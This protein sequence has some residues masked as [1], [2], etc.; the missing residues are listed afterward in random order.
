M[1]EYQLEL[2]QI[3]DY[4][5]CRIYRQF[6]G[7]LMK[8]K[9]IRVGGTS[10]LYHFTVLSCFANFRTSYKRID[11]I[12][13]TIYPGEWLCRVSE[14][15]EWFRTRFQHQALAILREL[16]DRH[17][18]TY[19]LL[20]RGKL[21]KFKIKGWCKY[22]RVLEYNAP[23]QK[24]TGFFFLPISVAN[25]LVSAG[26]CSEM[27]AMPKKKEEPEVTAAVETTEST[28]EVTDIEPV[29]V[30]PAAEVPAEPIKPAV[31][32]PPKPK[33][34]R[35]KKTDA[36]DE[37]A[38][39]EPQP[40]A[41]K[42]TAAKKKEAAAADRQNKPK[43]DPILTLEVGGEVTTETHEMDAAWHEIL[44]SN[45]S[46][47][48]LTGM[49]GGVEETEAGKT[50]AVVDYKGF[51]VVIPLKEMLV[52]LEKNLKGTEYTEMIRRQNKLLSNMLGCEIDFI[53]KGVDQKTRTVVASRKEAM[54]KKRQVFYMNQDASGAYRIY[55]GRTVQARVIAVAEKA[56]RI[57]AFGVECSI[58]ARDLS[59]DWIGD[60]NDRFSVGDQILVRI[61]EVN[62]DSLEELSIRADVKSVSENTN[63]T[64]LKQC[65][66]QSK[67]A[68]KVTDVHKGVVYVRLNNGAN[69][70]AHTCLD[71]RTPGKKD[72]VSFAVTH[73]DEDRS[74][75]V[76]IITRI[77]KQHL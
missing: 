18:N 31:E 60:A 32:E 17:L 4:P 75:A 7:L 67:Y 16:Q 52:K 13:Y 36:V 62:R 8:D 15:T 55:E 47:R 42:E 65:R 53:V 5:R 74:V 57:E 34:T 37:E 41:P 29:P 19:T 23:C 6:I 51:R 35:K 70:I 50:L 28:A 33:R 69:A 24:D 43:T 22:N 27:D 21:V 9:N 25:E 26:R 38:L 45:R 2:K 76:G 10:R 40:A 49:L 54:L 30:E 48:I 61:L 59:W 56:V 44:T 14:L 66:V 58:M 77:I 72:D 1:S 68:G 73:I 11:G 20:G 64:Y 63:R 71:R 46:H 3:V 39:P 12:S